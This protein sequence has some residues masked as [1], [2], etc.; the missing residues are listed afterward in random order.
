MC[1]VREGCVIC[2][3]CFWFDFFY[4]SFL[5]LFVILAKK[6]EIIVESLIQLSVFVKCQIEKYVHQMLNTFCSIILNANISSIL[7]HKSMLEN[8]RRF[9][10]DAFSQ[11]S[12]SSI[13]INFSILNFQKKKL[14][15]SVFLFVFKFRI[16]NSLDG[17]QFQSLDFIF[18][19]FHY[20]NRCLN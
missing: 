15:M 11:L 16:C 7:T 19:S 1:I 13:N 18:S 20:H 2:V 6:G 8:M 12:V 17:L 10:S 14:K 3:F 9:D 4:T 5:L